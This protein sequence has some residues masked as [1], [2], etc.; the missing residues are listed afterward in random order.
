MPCRFDHSWQRA[1]VKAPSRIA[2]RKL[3]HAALPG[4]RASSVSRSCTEAGTTAT[5]GAIGI[6]QGHAL[7]PEH[8]LGGV[9]PPGTAHPHHP[10]EILAAWNLDVIGGLRL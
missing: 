1:A 10:S 5:A 7:A 9:V 6:N 4:S 3:G 2:S 8:L